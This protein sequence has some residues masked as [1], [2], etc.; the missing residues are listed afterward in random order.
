MD[1]HRPL[2]DP[3]DKLGDLRRGGCGG[4]GEALGLADQVPALPHR[5][6]LFHPVHDLG[7]GGVHPGVVQSDGSQSGRVERA[8]E[9]RCNAS[10]AAEHFGGIAAP[11][12]AL[13]RDCAGL[14]F[15]VAG[16][17][18]GLFGER[19]CLHWGG[20]AA[21]VT[22]ERSDEFSASDLDALAAG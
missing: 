15:G 3:L 7:C 11:G 19:D 6:V 9:H 10:L 1:A 13:V 14:V 20:R 8:V 18:R 16:L 2:D 5:P 21:V 17:E 22:L 12:G 4:A